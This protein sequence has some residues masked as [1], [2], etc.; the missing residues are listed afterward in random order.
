MS[1]GK[2]LIFEMALDF[3]GEFPIESV[4]ENSKAA[5][6]CKKNYGLAKKSVLRLSC[7]SSATKT[8]MVSD[9]SRVNGMYR[10][11]IPEGCVRVCNFGDSEYTIEGREIVT[12]LSP[13]I[14]LLYVDSNVEEKILDP[15]LIRSIAAYLAWTISYSLTGS[16]GLSQ[17]MYKLY[18]L[19]LKDALLANVR[20]NG[21]PISSGRSFW[22]ESRG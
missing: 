17:S 18:K 19:V 5:R 11:K 21:S 7:W 16:L 10:Y 8:E 20:E 9:F 12:S 1:K 4:D 3:I 14:K 6:L 13:P 22:L 15:L 2:L